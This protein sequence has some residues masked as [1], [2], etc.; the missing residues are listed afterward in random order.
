NKAKLAALAVILVDHVGV[1]AEQSPP[2]AKPVLDELARHVGELAAVDPEQFGEHCRQL[3][4]GMQRRVQAGVRQQTCQLRAADAA[5]ARLFVGVFSASDRFHAVVTPLLLAIGQFL[6]Q[7]VFASLR[8]VALGLALAA[9]VHEAQRLARRLQPEALSFVGAVLAAA[10][11]DADD[12]GD[13]AETGCVFPLSRRQREATGFLR[14]GISE[15]CAEAQAVPWAWLVGGGRATAPAKYGV[16]RASLALVQR[17]ADCYAPLPAFVELFAPLARL[18]DKVGARLPQFKLQQAPDAVRAQ[19]DGLRARLGEQLAEA[20][21][22]RRPLKLQH[23]RPMALVTVAP[24][25]ESSYNLETHY[26]PDRDRNE[27]TKLRRQVAKERRGA[28]RELRRDAQFLAGERLREQRAKDSAYASKM[29]KAWSVL[30]SDQSEMKKLDR[31][32]IKERKA[33]V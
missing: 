18:L 11:C 8:D 13:W 3:V 12:A 20:R 17:F 29:K 33:K 23:H 1:L 26:D 27:L 24:K 15:K 6:G 2:V 21:A 10:V 14:I 25:F 32:R 16:L 5:L 9:T 30:E 22:A 4:V 31:Q 19:L 7:H 28:V